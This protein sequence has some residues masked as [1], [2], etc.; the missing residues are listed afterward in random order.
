MQSH[1]EFSIN[2]FRCM[3]LNLSICIQTSVYIAMSTVFHSSVDSYAVSVFD[4]MSKGRIK[5]QFT[6]ISSLLKIFVIPVSPNK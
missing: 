2:E 1:K 3:H 5:I 4:V 6:G